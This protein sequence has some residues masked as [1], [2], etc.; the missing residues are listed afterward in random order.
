MPSS[1]EESRTARRSALKLLG[2]SAAGATAGAFAVAA[3]AAATTANGYAEVDSFAGTTDDEKLAAAMAYAAAQ[4][5]APTLVFGARAYTF[6]ADY[7]FFPGMRWSGPLG[8]S[9]TEFGES[10]LVKVT[11]AYL[12]RATAVR[13]VAI[14]GI[15]FQG[16]GANDF[17]QQVTDFAAGPLTQ[18]ARYR[19]IGFKSFRSVMHA[20]HLRCSIERMYCNNGTGTQFKIGGSDSYYFLEGNS[21]LSSPSLPANAYYWHFTHMSESRFGELYI[22]T[23]TATGMRIDGSYGDLQLL[24]TKFDCTG[25]TGTDNC[26]GAQIIIA[27]GQGVHLDRCWFYGGMT[28]PAATGRTGVDNGLISITGG[29]EHLVTAPKFGFGPYGA[30]AGTK[31]VHAS[32]AVEIA[33]PQAI[34]FGGAAVTKAG[35]FQGGS[36]HLTAAAPGWTVVA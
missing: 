31:L 25:R 12:L 7:A 3:P 4:T 1:P 24:G 30:P 27:G 29:T 21:Y 35:A 32:V 20:R 19:E 9:E 14:R 36:A 33:H 16:T 2:V 11:G 34:S 23:E 10:C 6:A 28:N 5:Y 15:C 22:T 26:Q 8:G 13:D 18:D 17:Q